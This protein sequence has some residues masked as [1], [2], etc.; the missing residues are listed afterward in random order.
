MERLDNLARLRDASVQIGVRL[1]PIIPFVT[2]S[3]DQFERLCLALSALGLKRL[4]ASYLHLRPALIPLMKQDLPPLFKDLVFTSF[5]EK[6]I[7]KAWRPHTGQIDGAASAGQ[8]IRAIAQGGPSFRLEGRG[9][10][11]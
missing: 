6:K 2:D 4:T 8:R 11:L 9:L 3:L 7:Q 5:P 1:D 10:P